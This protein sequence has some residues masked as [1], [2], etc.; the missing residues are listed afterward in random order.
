MSHIDLTIQCSV[1]VYRD[2]FKREKM[3]LV[4]ASTQRNRPQLRTGALQEKRRYRCPRSSNL[5]SRLKV[6]IY[7]T[8]MN[9]QKG[10]AHRESSLVQSHLIR[11]NCELYAKP[12]GTYINIRWNEAIVEFSHEQSRLGTLTEGGER[13]ERS[14]GITICNGHDS[15]ELRMTMGFSLEL[16]SNHLSSKVRV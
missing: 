6:H 14:S 7:V 15:I 3:H 12:A 1:S 10:A 8:L 9:Y 11:E 5:T 16:S 13:L 2:F 4:R